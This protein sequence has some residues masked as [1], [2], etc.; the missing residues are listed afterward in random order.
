[1]LDKNLLDW[2]LN[3]SNKNINI[4]IFL[5]YWTRSKILAT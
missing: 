4:I 2:Q 3:E 5:D 1:M